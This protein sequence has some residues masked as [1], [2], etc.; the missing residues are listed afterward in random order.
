MLF[1][2]RDLLEV[3]VDQLGVLIKIGLDLGQRVGKK[4]LQSL[5]GLSEAVELRHL[6]V[7]TFFLRVVLGIA[8]SVIDESVL[9]ILLVIFCE[10]LFR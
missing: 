9:L 10:P 7:G 1:L 4:A 8:Y 5:L 6:V 3:I 2:L